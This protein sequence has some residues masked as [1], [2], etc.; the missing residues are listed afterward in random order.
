ML[1]ECLASLLP[2]LGAANAHAILVDNHSGDHSVQRLGDWLGRHDS[3]QRIE[4]LATP[5]NTGFAGG[6]NTAIR[7][8]K[9]E[10]YM[11]LNSDTLVRKGAL[12]L[13]LAQAELN[14]GHGLFSPR[15]EWPDGHGQ[16]STFRYH[17]PVSEFMAAAQTGFID[18]LLERWF[19]ACPVQSVRSEPEWTSFACVMIRDEVFRDVGLLDE[20]FF[21]YYEDAEFCA[22]AQDAGW[23]VLHCP[24]ARVA[25]LR[26]GSSPVKSRARERKRLPRYYYESRTRYF[27]LRYGRAGPLLANPAWTAGRLISWPRELAGRHDKAVPLGKER[28]IWINWLSPARPYTHPETNSVQADG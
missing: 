21:M 4:L 10:Y 24:E 3:G 12:S 15:L 11:L 8:R 23:P 20:V 1:I 7:Y 26:G 22:R 16:E 2:E 17:R 6:N 5:H 27:Y 18:H 25:H 14:P 9:A 28:D 19:I 13:L